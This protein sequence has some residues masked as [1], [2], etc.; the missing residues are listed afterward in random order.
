MKGREGYRERVGSARGAVVPKGRAGGAESVQLR[1]S[2]AVTTRDLRF[3]SLG[4]SERMT[5][6]P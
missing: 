5:L 4:P 1:L 2:V 3:A 6:R